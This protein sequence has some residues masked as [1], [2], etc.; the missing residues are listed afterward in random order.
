[1]YDDTISVPTAAPAIG[2]IVIRRGPSC[3]SWSSSAL[4][5]VRVRGFERGRFK[6]NGEGLLLRSANGDV[7][8]RPVE[9]L[10]TGDECLISN[11]SIEAF[12]IVVL[13]SGMLSA[14][15]RLIFFEFVSIYVGDVVLDRYTV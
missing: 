10:R 2:R 6:R 15:V 11:S 7:T 5:G 14:R 4:I 12:A 13:F 1:V 9:L 8:A 3:S